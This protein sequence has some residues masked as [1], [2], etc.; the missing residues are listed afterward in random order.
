VAVARAKVSGE[1][2]RDGARRPATA[3]VAIAAS[4][5]G[6]RA[7][8]VVLRDLPADLPAAV[9]IVQHLDPHRRSLLAEI[10]DR[11]AALAVK[12][13]E[14]GEPLLAGVA[15]VAPPGR[16][17]IVTPAGTI[18]LTSDPPVRFLRPAA[19]HLFTAV[20]RVFGERAIAVVLTGTGSDGAAGVAEVARCEGAVVVQE[21]AT[22]EFSAM[23]SAAIHT[24]HA[25]RIVPLEAVGSAVRDLL[26]AI[27]AAASANA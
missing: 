27:G 9:L 3:V 6:L 19:D 1:R 18:V 16:H 15:Y 17:M 14:E 22:A 23:P 4:A 10:L 7:M 12:Q 20:A 25:D 8:Q 2:F 24:G 11:D 21:A 5:G 26:G 13:G